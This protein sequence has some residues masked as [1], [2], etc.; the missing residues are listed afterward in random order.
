[1][2]LV[3]LLQTTKY[4]L[5]TLQRFQKCDDRL[6]ADRGTSEGPAPRCLC[7]TQ[8]QEATGDWC[9][10]SLPG[11]RVFSQRSQSRLRETSFNH[12]GQF[13]T[14][15]ITWRNIFLFP[16]EQLLKASNTKCFLWQVKGFYRQFASV[17][18]WTTLH[19]VWPFVAYDF[20]TKTLKAL[21]VS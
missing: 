11:I 9:H 16:E 8:P 4:P 20:P 13:P 18:W 19:I 17:Q 5:V 1:M 2:V 10:W 7:A 12:Q 15:S 21:F 6:N 3:D 14:F